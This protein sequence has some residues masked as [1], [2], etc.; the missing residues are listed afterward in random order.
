MVNQVH[1]CNVIA[2]ANANAH[3]SKIISKYTGD[4]QT[5]IFHYIMPV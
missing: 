1:T 3:A 4:T 2:N 5:K